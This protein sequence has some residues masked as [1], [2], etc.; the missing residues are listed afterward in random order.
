M[1]PN[2]VIPGFHPDPSVCQ[3]GEDYYLACSSFEY[4]PGAPIFHSRDLE[5]WQQVGN[6]L[7]RPSQ[8]RLAT[9][10]SSG[11]MYA[12]TLRHHDGRFWLI[13]TNV[14]DRGHFIVTTEDPAGPWSEPVVLDDLPGVD[15]D[16][17]W[18][19]DGTC[20]CT[21]ATF[22]ADAGTIAQVAID[23]STGLLLGE[24]RP[25]WSGTGLAS[26]EAPH[27]YR[28]DDQ[29]YLLVSEGGTSRGHAVS[30][31]RAPA[32]TG[33]FEGCP[34]NPVLSHR[35]TD[36]PVQST[37]HGDLVRAPDGSWQLLLLG[38]RPR[39]GFPGFHVLG[40]ET[41]RT[42]VRW[43]EGWPLPAPVTVDDVRAPSDGDTMSDGDT[44]PDRTPPGTRERDDF[45][46][47]ALASRWISVRERV[48]ASF[49]LSDRPGWLT[50]H[51]SGD[52]LD[53]PVPTFVG[54]RQEHHDGRVRALLD[55]GTGRGGLGVRLDER[56]HVR[57]EV[58]DGE[59][60]CIARIGPAIQTLAVRAVEPGPVVLGVDIEASP[61]HSDVGAPPDTL[62]LGLETGGT[63]VP[64]AELD[65]RYLSSEVAGGFTGRVIGVF[66]T[67]GT[68]AVD[69]FDYEGG[70]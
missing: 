50:L 7:D 65:G 31:A 30:V 16:L 39:G 12:P 28:I 10:P 69:W 61:A 47:P 68:I 63:F 13:T 19:E 17:A 14:S 40:R 70:I 59:V 57:I 43:A 6:A 62:R 64:L 21:F 38:V 18:D 23:P 20:W 56:H 42:T 15:P 2:P 8:L 46:A 49:S 36:S 32:A 44:P 41:F 66:A 24:P 26:P 48:P 29:W 34:A 3:V 35:S 45:D 52:S 1:P 9:A 51:G 22:G 67:E 55:P 58:A 4:F 33:P 60:R 37:G 5:T 53:D 25:I 11:G 27:L 54:R